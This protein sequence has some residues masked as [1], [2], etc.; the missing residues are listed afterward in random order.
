MEELAEIEYRL[1][2]GTTEKLQVA[3][4]VSAFTHAKVAIVK[5]SKA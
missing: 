3:S 2:A 5:A 4:L 1:S